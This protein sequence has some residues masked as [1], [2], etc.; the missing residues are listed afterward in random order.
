ME[1]EGE[2]LTQVGEDIAAAGLTPAALELV[3]PALARR[4]RW[5][6]AVRLAGSPALVAAD[7]AG[8]GAASGGGRFAPLRAEEAHAFWMRLAEG[9]SVRPVTFRIGGVPAVAL[10]DRSGDLYVLT[11]TAGFKPLAA[12]ERRAID[13]GVELWTILRSDGPA[14]WHVVFDGEPPR[15]VP[16]RNVLDSTDPQQTT[17]FGGDANPVPTAASRYAQNAS[18]LLHLGLQ[19]RILPRPL[20][21]TR[22]PGVV[23]I[24]GR[25][26]ISAG[27]GLSGEADYLRSALRDVLRGDVALAGAKGDQQ[28]Q[29][30]GAQIH[31]RVDPR[32]DVTGDGKP[33]VSRNWLLAYS[34]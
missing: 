30:T 1:A 21:A 24:G 27:D 19:D 29:G 18:P 25:T 5:V 23:P 3:S 6:L 31:L 4:E 33:R 20:Q 15:W 28:G 9:F 12:G 17:A 34:L 8:L 7:E 16:S 14:A 10:S 2:D 26:T 22:Q 32:L 13:F 11:P